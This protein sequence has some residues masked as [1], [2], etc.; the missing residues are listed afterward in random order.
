LQDIAIEVG[1]GHD[2]QGKQRCQ[3]KPREQRFAAV[4]AGSGDVHERSPA[5][6]CDRSP[7]D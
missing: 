5:A 6:G 4:H 1:E 3:Q 7:L 2:Q